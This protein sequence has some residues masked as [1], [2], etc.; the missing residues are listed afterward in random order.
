MISTK[1]SVFNVA[2]LALREVIPI[3]MPNQQMASRLAAVL[4]AEAIAAA[5]PAPTCMALRPI[6]IGRR[7]RAGAA[8]VPALP[9]TAIVV[10]TLIV[11]LPM[12][13]LWLVTAELLI[14]AAW[15]AKR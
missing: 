11:C 10:L 2:R 3:H 12:V 7:P 14:V 8:L 6:W 4:S 9:G 13:P 1:R 15:A 5:M